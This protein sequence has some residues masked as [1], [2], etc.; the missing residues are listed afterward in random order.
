MAM[1]FEHAQ[2]IVHGKLSEE[3]QIRPLHMV[4]QYP[5][6]KQIQTLSFKV[7]KIDGLP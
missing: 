2:M 3:G 7:L 5:Q 4:T 6:A 1:R